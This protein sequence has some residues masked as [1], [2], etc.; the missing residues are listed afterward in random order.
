MCETRCMTWRVSLDA[1]QVGTVTLPVR[2]TRPTSFAAQVH[3]HD[4]L[5][6]LLGVGQ[7]APRPAARSSSSVPPRRSRAGDGPRGRSGLPPAGRASRASRPT[8]FSSPKP[9]II[10][11]RR[12][13]DDPQ[14][15]VHIEGVGPGPQ[16]EPLRQNNLDDVARLDVLLGPPDGGAKS[17]PGEGGFRLFRC[18]S[19]RRPRGGAHRATQSGDD[20]LDL[21]LGLAV[22]P[23]DLRRS[24]VAHDRVGDHRDPMGHVIK[25]KQR[26]RQKKQRLRNLEVGLRQ[27]GESLEVTDGV[28]AE[29]THQPSRE[30][31]ESRDGHR[32]VVLQ[33]PPQGRKRVVDLREN[34]APLASQ[35]LDTVPVRANHQ[36]GIAPQK[37]V[38][39]PLFSPL[40]ALQEK[41]VIAAV[42]LP[43]GGNG[44]FHV[45]QDLAGDGNQVAALGQLAKLLQAWDIHDAT[46][47]GLVVPVHPARQ[48]RYTGT[49]QHARA[50]Q[51]Q[52]TAGVRAGG[53][54]RCDGIR[55]GQACGV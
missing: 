49:Q 12:G 50:R 24:L 14:G 43:K 2:A 4:V 45:R 18:G 29:K 44:G 25:D 51:R 22:S 52:E 10:H 15:A 30:S 38:A 53:H 33:E 48:T 20:G 21:L 28:V 34:P 16:R 9:Q 54:Q 23:L 5:G 27:A 32:P 26:V 40:H 6:P 39:A 47:T 1:H 17:R 8:I 46:S 37:A 42:D 13:I 7:Q 19:P 55:P 3:Q 41:C 31:G 11:V 36:A 35:D